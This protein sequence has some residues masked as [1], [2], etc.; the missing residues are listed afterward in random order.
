MQTSS[1]S[2]LARAAANGDQ[3]SAGQLYHRYADRI[4]A[5]C[6][7]VLLDHA[8]AKDGSQEAWIKIFRN[9]ARY[10]GSKSFVAWARTIAVRAAIDEHRKQ[11]RR[12]KKETDNEF[13]FEN[14]QQPESARRQTDENAFELKVHACLGLLSEAQRAA[15][16]LRH[17]EGA[18]YAEIAQALQCSEGTVKTHIHRAARVLRKALAPYQ[19]VME[20]HEENHG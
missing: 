14:I 3:A 8:S 2:T 12:R 10:D 1:D 6:Y 15:F 19:E 11:G 16:T 17:Y 9:L 4:F 20:H 5:V 7:R 18:A 13:V